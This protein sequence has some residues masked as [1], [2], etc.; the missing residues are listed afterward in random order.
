[1]KL[2]PNGSQYFSSFI[3]LIFNYFLNMKPLSQV[4]PG[5]L[6]IQI[7]IQ[8]VWLFKKNILNQNKFVRFRPLSYCLWRDPSSKWDI[9]HFCYAPCRL[10]LVLNLFDFLFFISKW[11]LW[12]YQLKITWKLV[13][14][15]YAKLHWLWH[16][17]RTLII[18]L[19]VWVLNWFL[20]LIWYLV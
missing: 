5:L 15:S 17:F 20:E 1:M 14:K 10:V 6:N 9:Q 16:H 11:Q 8:T 18:L 12:F 7:Q 2:F 13:K 19:W 4:V 3:F